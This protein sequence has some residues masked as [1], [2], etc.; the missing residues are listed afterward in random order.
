LPGSYTVFVGG[1][2]PVEGA[3]GVTARFQITGQQKLRR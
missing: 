2:Q 3:H 1:S